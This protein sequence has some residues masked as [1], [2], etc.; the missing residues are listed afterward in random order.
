M[1]HNKRNAAI[2]DE[3]RSLAEDYMNAYKNGTDQSVEYMHFED[4]F[5]RSAY[6]ASNG[7]LIDY[8]MESIE[9]I[10]DNLYAFTVLVLTEQ[11]TWH[12]GED[13]ER[14]YNFAVRIEGTWYYVNGISHIPVDLQ[15]NLDP[16]K[17]LYDDDENIVDRGDVIA[18]PIN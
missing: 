8:E 11:A 1:W 13:Y 10:N 15:D 4:D 3:V 17:Y 18:E 2:P 16:S 14:V 6:I 7:K 5:V 12:G 9:K